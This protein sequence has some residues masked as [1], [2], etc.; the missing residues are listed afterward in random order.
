ARRKDLAAQVG[1]Q[2]NLR[3]LAAVIRGR[4]DRRRDRRWDLWRYLLAWTQP[5]Q[6]L[7]PCHRVQ[8]GPEPVRITQPVELDRRDQEGVEHRPGGFRFGQHRMA[9][10]VEGR[11]V[12]VVHRGKAIRV[13]CD[14]GRHYGLVLH[15]SYRSSTWPGPRSER[16]TRYQ[17]DITAP[18]ADGC[19]PAAATASR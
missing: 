3:R 18:R 4:P 6:A 2:R 5:A 14:D 9:A 8:P 11:G 13:T 7:V 12:L 10:G 1:R 17:N 15:A 19:A 16:H